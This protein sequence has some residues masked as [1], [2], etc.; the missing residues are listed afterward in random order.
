MAKQIKVYILVIL[1]VYVSN[2]VYGQFIYTKQDN[3]TNNFACASE[4][5][6]KNN[7]LISNYTFSINPSADYIKVN[8]YIIKI[9]KNGGFKD[10]IPID[11]NLLSTNK[12]FLDKTHY[13][14]AGIKSTSNILSTVKWTPVIYKL[15]TTFNI[16]N[17]LFLE[18]CNSELSIPNNLIIKENCVFTAF[19]SDLSSNIKL[20]KLDKNLNKIDSSLFTG[21]YI[22]HFEKLSNKLLLSG[23]GFSSGSPFGNNQIAELDTSFNVLSRF[24]LDSLGTNMIVSGP[25]T[26]S[27]KIA[28]SYYYTNTFE[29]NP[30]KYF[31]SGY[32]SLMSGLGT[33]TTLCG[34]SDHQNINAIINNNNNVLKTTI[35][36]KLGLH[37]MYRLPVVSSCYSNYHLFNIACS[38]YNMLN[39]FPPQSNTTEIMVNK[40]D[41]LGN[42][43]W[44]NYFGSNNYYY[45]PYGINSTSDSGLVITGIRYN[46]S[47]PHINNSCEGFVLK[48]DKNG[49]IQYTGINDKDIIQKPIV[50]IYPNPA[51]KEITLEINSNNYFELEIYNS[52][53]ELVKYETEVKEKT[54]INTEDL[55]QGLYHF[56]LQSN[57][58]NYSGKFI[59]Q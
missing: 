55:P 41:T 38:G 58:N 48:L 47:A 32:T 57:K 56:K 17:V 19:Y 37:E 59:K 22:T 6:T 21:S 45:S 52:I 33:S 14:V 2:Y 18:E 8:S 16:V 50:N 3:F 9:N 49:V 26:C 5:I 13:Y 23:G 30:N 54:T 42:I 44:T 28:I 29:I 20:L 11:T 7:Y 24:N 34:N 12:V 10:S 39:P 4:D 27:Q 36:G 40:I 31:V 53:G 46:H 15:D 1:T 51:S 25:T 35:D 43:I